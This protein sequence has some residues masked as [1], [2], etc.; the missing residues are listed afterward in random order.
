MRSLPESTSV[1]SAMNEILFVVEKAEDR[2]YR[3]NAV[4]QAIHTEAD[5]LIELHQEIRDAVHLRSP[6]RSRISAISVSESSTD[7]FMVLASR[8]RTLGS[9]WQA[10]AKSSTSSPAAA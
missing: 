1:A 5:S 6:V 3:T 9:V 2:S 7:T 10:W 4:G 8:S